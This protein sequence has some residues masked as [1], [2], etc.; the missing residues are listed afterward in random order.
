[1]SR[2]RDA[3][4]RVVRGIDGPTLA[5]VATG[6]DVIEVERVGSL[7]TRRPA[8]R[9]VL[10]TADEVAEA[11][12]DG[13][14]ADDPIALRRLAARFAAKE[15][16]VKLLRRPRLAWVDVEVRSVPGGAPSLWLRGRPMP[17]AV[18]LAHDGAWAMAAVAAT[19]DALATLTAGVTADAATA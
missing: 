7:L 6:C 2:R 12:R 18:S 16:V 17:V 15:A 14:A 8:A 1:M 9:D 4:G 19:D 11:V 10:F 5:G 13:V 3:D